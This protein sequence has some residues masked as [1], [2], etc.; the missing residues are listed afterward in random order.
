MA[1]FDVDKL[2]SAVESASRR[3]NE[4]VHQPIEFSVRQDVNAV[5]KATI[6]HRVSRASKWLRSIMHG[7]P[8]V[9]SRMCQLQSDPEIAVRVG[10]E[11]FTV[12]VD[13]L[14]AQRRD[15]AL[16]C[17]RHQQLMRIGPAIL[18]DRHRF[19]A[20]DQL[21]A[22]DAEVAPSAPRQLGRLA[23]GRSI[24]S[25]HR[26]DAEAIADP[27]VADGDRLRER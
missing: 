15:R 9:A 11:A 10:A 17:R 5:R 7:R 14:V 24:P 16:R 21:G 6:E 19:S 13:R 20:P 26:Q 2:I 12:R 18:T 1:G 25:F 23:I 4:I 3:R 22:A 8:R 27:R